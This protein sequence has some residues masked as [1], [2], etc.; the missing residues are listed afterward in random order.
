MPK[1]KT[2]SAEPK[3]AG[4]LR[5]S[6]TMAQ[7]LGYVERTER[8][9]EEID[10]LTDDKKEVMEEAKSLGFDT[11]ILRVAIRRR[12]MDAAARQESDSILELYEEVIAQAEAKQ[13]QASIDAG[14]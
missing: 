1:L 10:G 13:K 7:L 4:D 6:N 12:K 14:E 9:Q 8:L 11:A 3:T 5:S 2:Q